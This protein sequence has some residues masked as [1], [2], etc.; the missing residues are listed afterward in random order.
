MHKKMIIVSQII[1][2]IFRVVCLM[3]FVT[4]IVSLV[5]SHEL[6][7]FGTQYDYRHLK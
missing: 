5:T 1:R 6:F 3:L 2:I 7:K 4:V